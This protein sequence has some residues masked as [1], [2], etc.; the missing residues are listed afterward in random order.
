MFL[1]KADGTKL[2][3]LIRHQKEA[4]AHESLAVQEYWMYRCLSECLH[5]TSA[6][7][8]AAAATDPARIP[9]TPSL[10]AKALC[11]LSYAMRVGHYYHVQFLQLYV[12]YELA[13]KKAGGEDKKTNGRATVQNRA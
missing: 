12:E 1:F 13:D 9:I 2:R 5:M 11:R 3:M 8:M 4:T 6:S 7:H 10:R